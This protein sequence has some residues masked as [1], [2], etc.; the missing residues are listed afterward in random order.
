MKALAKPGDVVTDP[1]GVPVV[2]GDRGIID[3]LDA[4]RIT[5]RQIQPQD[6]AALRRFHRRLS[7]H[8][9]HLRFFG[10]KPEL[11][12]R[13]ADYFT[14]VDWVNSFAL[15]ALDPEDPDEIIAIVSFYRE[16]STERAEYAAAVEDTWQGRGLGLA[17]T[18]ALITSALRRNVRVFT[19][20]ILP[21]NALILDLPLELSP[22][23][24]PGGLPA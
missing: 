22:R 7:Q 12:A 13:K 15:V 6:A 5:C 14:N 20:M 19:G 16:R 23:E 4:T 10:A 17:L 21:E 11:S 2:S 18:R 8:S 9:I 1:T 3:L 24:K